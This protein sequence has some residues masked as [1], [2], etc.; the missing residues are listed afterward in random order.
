MA[1]TKL[2]FL[3][4]QA[5]E[6]EGLGHA[7]IET[8]RDTPFTSCSREAGQNT[9]DAA[10]DEPVEMVLREHLIKATEIPG[11]EKLRETIGACLTS[12]NFS[13]TEKD[14]DFFMNALQVVSRDEIPVLEIAD[15]NT[16]GLEGPPND[17]G[18]KFHALVKS[19]GKSNKSTETSGGSF[20]IGKNATFAVSD[21]RTVF[22]STVYRSGESEKSAVQGK[23][24]LVSHKDAEG[25][26]RTSKGYWGYDE[27]FSAVEDPEQV[28]TWL[29]R[30]Q[31][32]T[33][34]FSVGFRGNENWVDRM[35]V[36]LLSN[37]F[38]AID[39]NKII[40]KV[41]ND[42]RLVNAETLSDLLEDPQIIEAADEASHGDDIRLARQLF[43]C[44][45]S[46]EATSKRFMIDGLGEFSARI[47][48]KEGMPKRV[49][50]IRNGML[51]AQS[52]EHFNDRFARF[53]GARDFILMVEPADNEASKILKSLENPQHNAFSAGRL[54]DPKKQRNVT[55]AMKRLIV[56]IRNLIRENAEIT[57][58][59]AVK[60]DELGEFFADA[61]SE[62]SKMPSSED[63]PETIKFTPTKR[64]KPKPHRPVAPFLGGDEGGSGNGDG[65]GGAGADSQGDGTG[66]GDGTAGT[67]GQQN[68]VRLAAI[69]NVERAPRVRKVFFTPDESGRIELAFYALGVFDTAELK[70]AS[71]LGSDRCTAFK[72]RVAVDVSKGNRV[73][74]EVTF[75]DDYSGPIELLGV[76]GA[77]K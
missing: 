71:A 77:A 3:V 48:V 64:M 23:V 75:E 12:A 59:D 52:L 11:I 53:P 33:S 17:S 44:R 50:I 7:G 43:Q 58:G 24:Q 25:T 14:V 22:Y 63:D 35:T 6:E 16:T 54:D 34:V 20:G 21:L 57:G 36:P 37:F 55:R 18:S 4:N 46:E 68:V 41:G 2:E 61:G 29:R 15:F 32:G 19:T 31:K 69:R 76:R 70:V 67:Q 28:P 60:L 42:E 39:D 27:D 5:G 74:I 47:L 45:K 72:G 56:E 49:A 26:A 10:D 62:E 73:E 1:E 38:A 51:I 13:G 9:L 40:F 66:D 65:S 30:D 8:F